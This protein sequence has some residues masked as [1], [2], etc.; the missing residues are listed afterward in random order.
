M[1]VT[2]DADFFCCTILVTPHSSFPLSFPTHFRSKTIASTFHFCQKKGFVKTRMSAPVCSSS[3]ASPSMVAPSS[4]ATY[5]PAT[6]GVTSR[7]PLHH[8]FS[9]TA[10]PLRHRSSD[11]SP[12]AAA[13]HHYPGATSGLPPP[14]MSS[15]RTHTDQVVAPPHS[16]GRAGTIGPSQG[17]PIAKELAQIRESQAA[18]NPPSSPQSG[19][20]SKEEDVKPRSLR[21]TWSMKTTSTLAPDDM[22]RLGFCFGS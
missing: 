12:S 14:Y 8:S 13:S 16:A 21:F 3:T 11:C 22:M 5:S 7:R 20:G 18:Q 2:S 10:S 4:A 19:N 1:V 6:T 17:Y 9:M 15:R